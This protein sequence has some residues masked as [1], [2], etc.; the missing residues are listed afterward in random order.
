MNKFDYVKKILNIA[1]PIVLSNL[2][3]QIEMLVDRMFVG[4]L[5]I[6][7]MSAVGNATTPI[8]T[9][10]SA[11]FS[12]TTGAAILLS[13]KY[14]AGKK[15][16][17]KDIMASV[18]KFNNVLGV[19]LFLFWLLCPQIVFKIMGVDESIVG[20]SITYAKVYSPIF[21]LTG[22]GASIT[23]LLQVSQRT[24]IM[25]AYGVSRS[26]INI[27]L[28]YGMIF[29]HFGFSAMG[30][31]GAALATVIAEFIGDLIVLI[32]VLRSKELWLRP[33]FKQILVAK[34]KPYV[35]TVKLGLPSALE[36]FA[37]NFGNLFIIAMLNK[38]SIEAAGIHSIVFGIECV[39]VAIIASVGNATLTLTGYETGKEN[40]KGVW[41]V[42]VQS[43]LISAVI[44]A[45]T[46][47]LFL[48]LPTQILSCFTKD[49]AIIAAAPIFLTIVGIDLFP[50]S[51][52]IIFGSG[53]KGCGEPSWMLKT[54]IF[55]TVFIV[56]FSSLLVI[57][58]HKGIIELF[59][60]V[61]ADEAIRFAMNFVKFKKKC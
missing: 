19:A 54:Q 33:K 22:I 38:I 45:V 41:D 10:M 52:N 2:I 40:K 36:D 20:M 58:L 39:A 3:S 9:T 61:V 7:C 42:V 48:V 34:F 44:S 4:K 51:G 26:L 15:D 50:K 35:H 27:V 31:K 60:L 16:E 5:D 11:V 56:G 46:L 53:I 17:A 18:L 59:C 28:D 23:A 1:I 6:T 47:A 13:Q 12:L 43:F 21:I 30:V 37:W 57:V 29:G 32:Y 25:I 49:A 8:W 55:G 14:G 24:S